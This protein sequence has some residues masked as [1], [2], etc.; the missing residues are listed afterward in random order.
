M[1]TLS[2]YD[3]CTFNTH[4]VGQ[5]VSGATPFMDTLSAYDKHTLYIHPIGQIV[6]GTAPLW[7]HILHTI[8]ARLAHTLL[9]NA[10]A[11]LHLYVHTFYR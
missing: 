6:N 10:L 9:D 2:A 8:D 7:T 11:G 5:S 4:H 1:D 3:I